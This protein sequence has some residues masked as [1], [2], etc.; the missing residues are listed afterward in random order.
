MTQVND[1]LCLTGGERILAWYSPL[2][3]AW[4]QANVVLQFDHCFGAVLHHSNTIIV[5]GGSSHLKVESYDMDTGVWSICD[6]ETPKQL[7]NAHGLKLY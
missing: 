3:D 7:Y 1:K 6:W 5:I 4:S 2:T